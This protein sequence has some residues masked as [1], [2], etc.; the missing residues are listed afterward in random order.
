MAAL[1]N[2]STGKNTY[3]KHKH[4][5]NNMFFIIFNNSLSAVPWQLPAGQGSW[6]PTSDSST[7][8]IGAAP[9]P[10]GPLPVATVTYPGTDGLPISGLVESA[11]FSS[12]KGPSLT[13]AGVAGIDPDNINNVK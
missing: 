5:R 6:W 3:E 10:T 13:V 2:A 8:P 11:Q 9:Y 4:I 12:T 1:L 7:P